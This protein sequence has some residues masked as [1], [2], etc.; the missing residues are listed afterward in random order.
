MDLNDTPSK[1]NDTPSKVNRPPVHFT[2]F[3]I[4]TWSN[5]ELF[6]FLRYKMSTYFAWNGRSTLTKGG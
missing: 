1:V 3:F 6:D 2:L 4:Y 5:L